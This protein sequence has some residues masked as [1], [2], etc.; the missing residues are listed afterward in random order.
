MTTHFNVNHVQ[1]TNLGYSR[2]F[3]SADGHGN[4]AV[5]GEGPQGTR[6]RCSQRFILNLNV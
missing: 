1:Q 2:W 4:D 5:I 3:D 6:A